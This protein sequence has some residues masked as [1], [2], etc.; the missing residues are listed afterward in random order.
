MFS[1]TPIATI[2]SCFT[3]RFGVPRQAG[4]VES[5][6]AELVFPATEANKLA[7]RGLEQVS[8]LWVI[9]VF[10]QQPY[11]SC[12][13]LVKPPRLGGGQKMGVFATRSPNRF[14]PI[15]MSVVPL[16]EIQFHLQEII[17][18]LQGGDFLDGTPVLDIKPYIVYADSI[19]EATCAWASRSE[20]S[21]PVQWC[22]EALKVLQQQSQ[23]HSQRNAQ[24]TAQSTA[25]PIARLISQLNV[26]QLIQDTLAQDP[27]PGHE[28]GKDGKPAQTWNMQMAGFII[29]WQVVGGIAIVTKLEGI[30]A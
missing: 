2:R 13:P 15:G 20:G 5:A 8:H 17:L 29:H 24:P 16:R 10:H 11:S 4:L 19:P 28:R 30:D 26:Q 21:M 25:Q 22:P 1:F 7:L 9:F 18:I 23:M 14:N 27:R 12:K 3:S 6:Y